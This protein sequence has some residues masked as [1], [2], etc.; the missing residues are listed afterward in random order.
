MYYIESICN[1]FSF[2]SSLRA[3]LGTSQVDWQPLEFLTAE[4]NGV[5]LLRGIDEIQTVLDDH[6]SK[7]QAIRSSHGLS[8]EMLEAKSQR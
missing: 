6:I 5:P 4:R 1:E 2:I 7:T 3:A 8:V